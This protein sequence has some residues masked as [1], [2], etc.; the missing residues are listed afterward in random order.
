MG[1]YGRIWDDTGGYIRS[2]EDIGRKLEDM[3]V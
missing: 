1:E 2:W 3:G